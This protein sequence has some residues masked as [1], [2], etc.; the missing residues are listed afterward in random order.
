VNCKASWSTSIKAGPITGIGCSFSGVYLEMIR[1]YFHK[2]G[3]PGISLDG[4]FQVGPPS[5]QLLTR[6]RAFVEML[7]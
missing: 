7:N 5:G 3:V 2:K 1:D 4:S 6:V